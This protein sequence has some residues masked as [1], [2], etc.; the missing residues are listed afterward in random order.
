L[1]DIDM[2]IM[3]GDGE[4]SSLFL[5]SPLV[6]LVGMLVHGRVFSALRLSERCAIIFGLVST[7]K[8][9]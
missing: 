8:D 4:R 7:I 3:V 9:R 6:G 1:L 5:G 2:E